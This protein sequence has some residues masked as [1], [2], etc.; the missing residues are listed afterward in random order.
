MSGFVQYD[1]YSKIGKIMGYLRKFRTSV[2][3]IEML[4]NYTPITV[5]YFEMIRV[6]NCLR[7]LF[8]RKQLNFGNLT[9]CLWKKTDMGLN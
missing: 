2:F 6:F 8:N 1:S 7:Y 5:V 4:C 3:S 9:L